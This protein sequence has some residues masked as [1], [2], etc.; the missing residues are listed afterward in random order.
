MS[1]KKSIL[2]FLIAILA[3][4]INAQNVKNKQFTLFNYNL[5]VSKDFVEEIQSLESFIDN[6]KTYN[7]PGNDKLNAIL[8]HVIYY[9][10]KDIMMQELEMEILPI[11][12]FMREVK[13]DDYGYPNTTIRDAIRKGDS[14]FYFKVE[15]RLESLTKKKREDSPELFEDID[16]P[17]TY[18]ELSIEITVNNKD[19][20][21]PIARWTGTTTPKY[22]L[23][24]NNYLLK[25]FDNNDMI[26]EPAE[27]NQT[28]NLYLMLDRAI[29]NAIQDYYNK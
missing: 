2:F 14:K 23:A 17:V 26:I 11:N 3:T 15:A 22:P 1:T 12:T 24:I 25:G 9:N 18:P 29:H 6:V 5:S 19:G 10:L 21:I 28:D 8:V 27:N 4:N 16:Y 7:D 13:Y 20:I